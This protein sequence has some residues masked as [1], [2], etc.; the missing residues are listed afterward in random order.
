ME[1]DGDLKLIVGYYDKSRN[2]DDTIPPKFEIILN[3]STTFANKPEEIVDYSLILLSAQSNPEL[4][5]S[6]RR[7]TLESKLDEK[8]FWRVNNSLKNMVEV[9]NH[10][11]DQIKKANQNL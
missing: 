4:Y 3:N 9:Y 7:I 6:F 11:E 10:I 2:L 8:L 1:N 5:P